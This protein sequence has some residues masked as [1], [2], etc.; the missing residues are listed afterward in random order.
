[1]NK[2][3][4]QDEKCCFITGRTTDV[5]L[6]HIYAWIFMIVSVQFSLSVV[7][8]S[9]RSH[10]SQDARLPCPSPTSGACSDLCTLSQ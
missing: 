8:D 7:S 6:H 10:E 1:M 2:S 4:L 5:A 9:W 3:I